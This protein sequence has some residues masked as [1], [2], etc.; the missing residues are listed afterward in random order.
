MVVVY[1]AEVR[2]DDGVLHELG[3][4][5]PG[6]RSRGG[7]LQPAQ[8][9]GEPKQVGRD[10]PESGVRAA[11]LPAGILVRLGDYHAGLG[12]RFGDAARPRA[13]RVSLR[14]QKQE[15]ESHGYLPGRFPLPSIPESPDSC[16]RLGQVVR[17]PNISG[18]GT[19]EGYGC[20]RAVM[21]AI[22]AG[23]DLTARM[24][25]RRSSRSA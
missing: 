1:I 22:A 17:G 2:H 13:G 8:I 5:V 18:N 4:I 23:K 9:A 16:P 6:R 11:Y 20:G 10:R 7:G 21:V 3:V 19:S 24:A 25:E 14:R 12:D 15:L